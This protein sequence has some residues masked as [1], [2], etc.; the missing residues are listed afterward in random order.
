MMALFQKE[1][2][3]VGFNVCTSLLI[4]SPRA[5]LGA[6]SQTGKIFLIP[7]AEV[8]EVAQKSQKREQKRFL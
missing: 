5:A 1:H 6:K 8:A 4:P 7:D 3:R 2:A